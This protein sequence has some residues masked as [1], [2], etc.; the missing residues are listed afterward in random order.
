MQLNTNSNRVM[1]TETISKNGVNLKKL[2]VFFIAI[3]TSIVAWGQGDT[4]TRPCN[5]MDCWGGKQPCYM[6]NGTGQRSEVGYGYV[7]YIPCGYC[8]GRGWFVCGLCKGSGRL[9]DY[10][11]QWY[12]NS[13]T[14]SGNSSS[15]S[16]FTY[17][18]TPEPSKS[19]DVVKSSE[20]NKSGNSGSSGSSSSGGYSGGS[21]NYGGGNSGYSSSSSSTRRTCP[22]CNGTC[23][24]V[25][26]ITYSPNYTGNSN[27]RYCSQCGRT[28][29]AHSHHASRCGVCS[30]RGYVE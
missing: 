16:G 4:P 13:S 23:K 20:Q 18:G 1:E 19:E 15:S 21:G 24:G 12:N 30:G 25:D 17:W 9:P 26:Q 5:A 11:S 6:C 22:G 28:G 2:I 8:G 3:S 7:Y 27:D 10:H 14:N 29:P